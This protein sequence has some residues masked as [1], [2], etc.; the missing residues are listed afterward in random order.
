M[1]CLAFGRGR[2]KLKFERESSPLGCQ[3]WKMYF[4]NRL[5]FMPKTIIG[6]ESFSAE[7]CCE[8]SF[9]DSNFS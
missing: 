5:V 1:D 7:L 8:S 6:N 4:N 2:N 9:L 3:G